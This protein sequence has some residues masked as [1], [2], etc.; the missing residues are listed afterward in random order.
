MGQLTPEEG[1]AE[2]K[3]QAETLN[4]AQ[5]L[6]EMNANAITLPFSSPSK[7]KGKRGRAIAPAPFPVSVTR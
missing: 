1:M 2:Y 3:A 5:A 4:V 7:Y 6:E